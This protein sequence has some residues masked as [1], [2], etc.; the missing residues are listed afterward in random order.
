MRRSPWFTL[1]F[2]ATSLI[3]AAWLLFYVDLPHKLQQWLSPA[4]PAEL[5]AESR[6][7]DRQAPA[8]ADAPLLSPPLQ[9]PVPMVAPIARVEPSSV[10]KLQPLFEP[11]TAMPE[12]VAISK[13]A[14]PVEPVI[15]H[16]V[17][18]ELTARRQIYRLAEPVGTRLQL[19]GLEDCAATYE[20]EPAGGVLDDRR[21]VS[22]KIVG[23]REVTLK[24]SIET[25]AAG[26][27]VLC[28]EPTLVTLA[29]ATKP[30][31]IKDL[32]RH[33]REIEKDGTRAEGQLAAMQARRNELMEFI[34]APALKS[35]AAR[36]EAK[37]TVLQLDRTIP[38]AQEQLASLE[39]EHRDILE[40]VEFARE[41]ERCRLQLA[42]VH[43]R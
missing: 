21:P 22:I 27:S 25:R 7:A 2:Y 24:V 13:D 29:G 28:I 23:P 17:K 8:L 33:Q 9:Q 20:I 43:T 12:P 4:T 34:A 36:G 1:L 42:R 14:Q 40:L 10:T 41:L 3:P 35:L 5:P 15:A 38:A 37:R 32:A 18:L 11:P 30:L 6:P 31:I 26:Q 19:L 39:A 16:E